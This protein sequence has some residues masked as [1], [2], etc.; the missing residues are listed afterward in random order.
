MLCSLLLLG[1]RRTL[2]QHAIPSIFS[3]APSQRPIMYIAQQQQKRNPCKRLDPRSDEEGVGKPVALYQDTASQG[4]ARDSTELAGSN[5]CI[6]AFEERSPSPN[7][8]AA[9]SHA[10]SPQTSIN[11]PIERGE[12]A[13]GSYQRLT[14]ASCR[15]HASAPPPPHTHHYQQKLVAQP[16]SPSQRCA[17][18]P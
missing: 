4:A 8:S 1:C 18:A 9:A 17:A 13:A 15:H 5:R 6:P 12:S 16:H 14:S 11:S 2:G 7:P 10:F 3:R